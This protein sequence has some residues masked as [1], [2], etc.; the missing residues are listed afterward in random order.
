MREDKKKFIS[1]LFRDNIE[2]KVILYRIY[3]EILGIFDIFVNAVREAIYR[4][5]P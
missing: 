5:R 1:I 4:D 3:Y 2:Y